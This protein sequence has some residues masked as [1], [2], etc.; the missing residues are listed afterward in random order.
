[1]GKNH[2]PNY[3]KNY[4]QN[5]YFVN[6]LPKLQSSSPYSNIKLKQTQN[7]KAWVA[8]VISDLQCS[9]VALNE[10]NV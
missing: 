8:T 2:I 9:K 6:K 5:V 7:H 4:T 3:R 1:M 10:V